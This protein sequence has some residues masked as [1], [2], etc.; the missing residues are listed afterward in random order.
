MWRT[1][2]ATLRGNWSRLVLTFITVLLGATFVSGALVVSTSLSEGQQP[3]RDGLD[4]LVTPLGRGVGEDEAQLSQGGQNRVL[5][6]EGQRATL[7]GLPGVAAAT[8]VVEGYAAVAGADGKVLVSQGFE[9]RMTGSNWTGTD[10]MSLVTG[11]APAGPTEV[12]LAESVATDGGIAVGDTTTVLYGGGKLQAAVVGVYDYQPHGR[13]AGSSPTVAFDTATAQRLLLRPG[14]FTS[15]EVTATPGTPES[16]LTMAV[17]AA[18]PAGFATVDR[19]ELNATLRAATS[20]ITSALSATVLAFTGIALVVGITLIV[21]TFSMLVARRGRE[22]AL[23][24]AVGATRRQVR[25]SVLLEAAVVGVL[26][27]MT[28]LVIGSLLALPVVTYAAE[29]NPALDGGVVIGLPAVLGTLLVGTG[30]T[31]VA[32]WLPARRAASVPPVAA[33]GG[34]RLEEEKGSRWLLRSGLAMVGLSLLLLIVAAVGEGTA[35]RASG[36]LGALGLLLSAVICARWLS[37]PVIGLLGKPL[38]RGT[39]GG[40]AVRN[41]LRSP[42]RTAATATALTIGVAIAIGI[43]IFSTTISTISERDLGGAFVGRTV[44]TNVAGGQIGEDTR[45]LVEA[46]PSVTAVSTL[47]TDQ[48]LLDGKETRAGS[49]DVSALGR[50]VDVK[51]EQGGT[52]DLTRGVFVAKPVAEERGWS[53]GRQVTLTSPGGGSTP[54][55]ITGIFTEATV[56]GQVVLPPA[57]ADVHFRPGDGNPM[58]VAT[59]PGTDGAAVEEALRQA[60]AARSDLAVMSAPEYVRSR[61]SEVDVYLGAVTGLLGL[62][63]LIAFLGIINTLSLSVLERGRELGLLRA[64]GMTR[65]QIRG[66]IRVESV[67]IAA[68]GGLIGVVV[69]VVLGAMMQNFILSRGVFDLVVPPTILLA[70]V[71]ISLGGLLA[72]AWP[73]RRAARVNVIRAITVD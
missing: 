47:R 12:V 22:L 54:V 66:L 3:L 46:V 24:R 52:A 70:L 10:R 28:G 5:L 68:L 69:G 43:T 30:T 61:I 57:L 4:A 60:L 64:T 62:S 34:E 20:E 72:A 45:R 9:V 29:L 41:T 8:G 59:A 16:S 40:M 1:V 26:G 6:D 50:T 11:R 25:R 31:V 36:M 23:L 55:E 33:L 73:A 65:R 37:G 39:L 35:S 56:L 42:R 67:L 15:V 14:S 17:S 32:A 63:V 58:V 27:S 21:N 51:L 2:L 49:T 7:A 48:V 19:A 18:M 13:E 38:R 44:V 53:L 71:G